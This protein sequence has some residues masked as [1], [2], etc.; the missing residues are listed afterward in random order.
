[1]KNR[2]WI[3][4]LLTIFVAAVILYGVSAAL[5]GLAQENGRKE[6]AEKMQTI[7]PGSTTFTEE[8]YTGEDTNIRSVWAGETGFVVQTT[9]AGYAG[10]ITMLIGVSKDGKVTG[11]QVRSMSETFGLGARG[12]TDEDFLAQFLNTTGDVQIGS[13]VDALTGATVTSRAIARSVNSAVGYVTGADTS[14]GATS[15]GG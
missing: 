9:T 7:L 8:I 13:D 1:M 14:S 2:S 11:L 15:W 6:L 10:D 12:L 4:P 5:S 3:L